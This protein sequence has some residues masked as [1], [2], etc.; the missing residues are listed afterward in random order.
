EGGLAPTEIGDAVH[1]LLELT[2]LA[3]PVAPDVEQV[4]GWYPRIADEELERVRTFVAAYCDSETARHV[5][6]LG[7]VAKERHFTF[8]HDAV[9]VH[10]QRLPRAGRRLRGPEAA[11]RAPRRARSRWLVATSRKHGARSAR[12]G[13]GSGRSSSG[14]PPSTPMPGSR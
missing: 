11:E 10:L 7:K 3:A 6:S 13:R 14:S 12:A 5:A 1:R 4:R 9:R 8:E 2:D